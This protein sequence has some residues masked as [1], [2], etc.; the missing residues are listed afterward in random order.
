MYGSMIENHPV[1][2]KSQKVSESHIVGESIELARVNRE[3]MGRY[4]CEANNAIPPLD[5]QL[6]EVEVQ[7]PPLITVYQQMVGS[8]VGASVTLE[9]LIESH[10]K[11]SVSWER[12]DGVNV[13]RLVD[14]LLK[15]HDF[16]ERKYVASEWAGGGE[17]D[18]KAVLN[19]TLTNSND[20]GMYFCRASNGEGIAKAGINLYGTVLIA[21]LE[22]FEI[23][24]LCNNLHYW[25][26]KLDKWNTLG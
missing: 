19:M 5:W 26:Q 24:S 10:P 14:S 15:T 11:A 20:F 6:F 25:N 4:R 17:Y 12:Y 18:R 16:D 9:C 3:H 7:F 23:P 22:P 13:G 21:L 8:I 2:L 1:N